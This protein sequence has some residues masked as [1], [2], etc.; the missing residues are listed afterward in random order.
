MEVSQPV[1]GGATQTVSG[2]GGISTVMA[3]GKISTGGGGGLGLYLT[4]GVGMVGYHLPALAGQA[5][6][7]DADLGFRSSAGLEYQVS[8]R[9]QL[10]AE[11]GQIWALHPGTG[12]DKQTNKFSQL[13]G[14]VRIGW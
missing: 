10:F 13:R 14:G 2:S 8:R 5:A 7:F 3:T 1:A 12:V 6:R 4:G 11:W 9:S